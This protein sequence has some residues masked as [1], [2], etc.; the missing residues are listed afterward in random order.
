MDQHGV[1]SLLLLLLLLRSKGVAED[2]KYFH[3][4]KT[5]QFIEK[6]SQSDVH[7]QVQYWYNGLLQAFY[8]SSTEKVVGFTHYG[9]VFADEVNKSPDYLKVR[10]NDLN[11]F[12]KVLGA[13]LYKNIQVK[14]VPPVSRLKSVTSN[15][16][17][18][19][20]VLVCSAYNFYPQQI[21][22]SWLRDG[23]VI[24]DPPGMMIT[25]MPGGEWRY[26]IHSYLQH[27]LNSGQ[28]ITCMIEHRGLQE[29]QLLKLERSEVQSNS[30]T[31][32]WE[33]AILATG[34]FVL[35]ASVVFHCR[36]TQ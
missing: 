36:K 23:V 4:L 29:P 24:P 26:Q 32:A 1:C 16:S 34:L 18:D 13:V 20:E 14:A 9:K 5:C 12:C 8:N 35:L 33:G 19:S 31:L 21:R 22:L 15:S 3:I 28:N 17:E 6:S 11:Y 30:V 7:Y 27:K 25:E 10:R 2:E